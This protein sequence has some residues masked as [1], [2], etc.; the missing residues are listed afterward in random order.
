LGTRNEKEGGG[1]SGS[2]RGGPV[3]GTG[4]QRDKGPWGWRK[5]KQ[6]SATVSAKTPLITGRS[7]SRGKSKH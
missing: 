4:F 6:A 2:T 3:E 7:E 5:E 1:K